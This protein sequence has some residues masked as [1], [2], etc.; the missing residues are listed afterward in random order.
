VDINSIS[1]AD[2]TALTAAG[3]V[4]SDL[5]LLQEAEV[6]ALLIDDTQESASGIDPHEA[7]AAEQDAAAQAA[8]AAATAAAAAGGAPQPDQG[9]AN[10]GQANDERAAFVPQFKADMP[11]DAETKIAELRT[12]QKTAFKAL[13]D[14]HIDADKYQETLDRVDASIDELKTKVLTATIF[15]Q[16]NEQAAEQAAR[17]EWQAAETRAMESFKAEGLDYK[18]KPALLAA[19]NTNLRTLGADP[20]NERRDAAWFLTEAHKATKN[21]LGI[22]T[23]TKSTPPATPRG[24][25][26]A[27]LPPTLRNVP[28]AGAGAVNADEFAH[29]RNLTGLA[30]E[31]AHAALT[32]DQ[33]NRWMAE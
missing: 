14:G 29:L 9:D 21:D 12:E 25:D 19:F 32:D 31:K 5:A 18:G 24:V 22:T 33:R 13:M 20:K 4:A 10:E 26:L 2:M 30:A 11:A 23:A 8:A 28:T 17:N 15:Q 7:A 27:D 1:Q 3:Y 6:K 16:A